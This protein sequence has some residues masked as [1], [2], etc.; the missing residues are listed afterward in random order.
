MKCSSRSI[1]CLDALNR[2]TIPKEILDRLDIKAGSSMEFSVDN[3]DNIVIRRCIP[4]LDMHDVLIWCDQKAKEY[5]MLG[6]KLYFVDRDHNPFGFFVN[7]VDVTNEEYEFAIDRWY[8][9]GET[10]CTHD[11]HILALSCNG[12]IVLFAISNA[13]K[14]MVLNLA[15]ELYKDFNDKSR[16]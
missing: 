7:P 5:R 13:T 11:N 15:N 10:L 8:L 16:P 9:Y 2:V 12:R 1:R 14:E 3:F 4:D 6:Y